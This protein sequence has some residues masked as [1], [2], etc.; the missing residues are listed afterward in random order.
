M[1]K[2][3]LWLDKKT[4]CAR[5]A[6][7]FPL[8]HRLN[9]RGSYRI[10]GM[11]LAFLARERCVGRCDARRRQAIRNPKTSRVAHMRMGHTIPSIAPSDGHDSHAANGLSTFALMCGTR[12]WSWTSAKHE[13]AHSLE[14]AHG[15]S[16]PHPAPPVLYSCTADTNTKLV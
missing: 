14:E 13:H 16:S 2:R 12:R 9:L 7:H 11:A 15:G 10:A 3:A 5:A 8:L 4:F 1:Y 6:S